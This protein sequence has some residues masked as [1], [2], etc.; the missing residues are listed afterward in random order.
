MIFFFKFIRN[1]LVSVEFTDIF[2]QFSMISKT[3]NVFSFFFLSK[4][5]YYK[6]IYFIGM[7]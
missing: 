5:N 2:V 6:N 3:N 4:L 1:Y 7:N